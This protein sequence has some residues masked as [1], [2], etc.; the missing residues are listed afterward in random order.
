MSINIDLD[1]FDDDEIRDYAKDHLDMVEVQDI[2]DFNDFE[3]LTELNR[4][5]NYSLN[6]DNLSI[7]Q[8]DLIDRFF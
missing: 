1:D 7:V 6:M 2:V 4:R 3:L 5:G 8:R